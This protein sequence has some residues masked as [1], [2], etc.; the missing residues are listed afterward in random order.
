MTLSVPEDLSI[1]KKDSFLKQGSSPGEE[2]HDPRPA[3][4]EGTEICTVQNPTLRGLLSVPRFLP[5]HTSF[6]IRDYRNSKM[7]RVLSCT[8]KKKVK[9]I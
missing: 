4:W 2:H 7:G 6:R 9:L 8:Q 3:F 5:L 1:F